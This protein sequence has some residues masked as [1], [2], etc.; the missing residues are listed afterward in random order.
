MS[1]RVLIIEDDPDFSEWITRCLPGCERSTATTCAAA[2]ATLMAHHFDVV[3][4]DL[5]LAKDESL[6]WLR[7][8]APEAALCC[9]TGAAE[10][11]PDGFDATDWKINLNNA[12]AIERLIYSAIRNRE[13]T[14]P[15]LRDVRAVEGCA[16]LFQRATA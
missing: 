4:L 8:Y 3:I 12:H 1:K 16:R 5:S 2:R 10:S 13:A 7:V 15:V 6:D 14:P 9:I 11:L